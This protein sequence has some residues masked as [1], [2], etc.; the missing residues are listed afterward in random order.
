[1]S[2]E[3]LMKNPYAWL[4]LSICTVAALVFAIYTWIKG[5]KKKAIAY[6]TQSYRLVEKGI[7]RISNLQISYLERNIDDLII[8]RFA[9][10]N[11]GNEVVNKADIVESLPLSINS[12]NKDNTVLLD[13][14][15]IDVTDASNNFIIK[16]LKDDSAIIGFDYMDQKE[17]VVVQAIHTGET[18]EL[19]I[20]CKIKGGSIKALRRMK[21]RKHRKIKERTV[22]SIFSVLSSLMLSIELWSVMVSV[23]VENSPASIKETTTHNGVIAKVTSIV[24]LVMIL[25]VYYSSYRMLKRAYLWDIPA[26]LRK[27]MGSEDIDYD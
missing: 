26:K 17:G 12:I 21:K 8:T 5:K 27:S 9:F 23:W 24:M 19:E 10:W 16:S 15:I 3:N 25:F 2:L 7:R 1:M 6:W 11:Y 13:V 14:S 4:L 18:R 20:S 22:L